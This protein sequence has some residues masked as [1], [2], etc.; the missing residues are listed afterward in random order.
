MLLLA[1]KK[2][3]SKQTEKISSGDFEKEKFKCSTQKSVAEV[4]RI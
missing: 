1:Y 4:W 2:T 3:F